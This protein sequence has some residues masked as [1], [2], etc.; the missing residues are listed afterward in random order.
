MKKRK[1]KA[2]EQEAM[3]DTPIHSAVLSSELTLLGGAIK[4]NQDHINTK[5]TDSFT[6]I[7]LAIINANFDAVIL[8]ANN[9]ANLSMHNKEGLT[10]MHQI[11]K[12]IEAYVSRGITVESLLNVAKA[13]IAKNMPLN[14]QDRRGN[15]LINYIAQKAKTNRESTKYYNKLGSLLLSSD[16]NAIDTVQ[17]K[18]NM[19]KTPMDYLSRNGNSILREEV[20]SYTIQKTVDNDF[21]RLML[22]AE[23]VTRR[24]LALEKSE[25][26]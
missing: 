18:N 23:L 15:S 11:I 10:P 4:N 21:A 12:N 3:I 22:E 6:P 14:A 5:N 7:E 8:L 2:I 25:A 20:Y 17:T 1:F 13:L 9:G 16:K 19:G 26:F 24:N